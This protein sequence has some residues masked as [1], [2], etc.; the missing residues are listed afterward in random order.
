MN[1]TV[2]ITTLE[3]QHIEEAADVLTR[4]FLKLNPI[5]KGYNPKYDQIFPVM[6]GKV[7]PTIGKG[8]SFVF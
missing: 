7:F 4:S 1:P 6:R 2:E 5:W 8:W 3:E